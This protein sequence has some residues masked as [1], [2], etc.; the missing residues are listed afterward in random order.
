MRSI[1]FDLHAWRGIG[2]AAQG[3]FFVFSVRLGFV[4]LSVCRACVIDRLLQL[5]AL[6]DD[7]EKTIVDRQREFDGR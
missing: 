7:A 5:K 3:D 6:I 1:A 2:R 4:T